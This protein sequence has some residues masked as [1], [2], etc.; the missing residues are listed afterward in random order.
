M[1][2]LADFKI[3]YKNIGKTD[4]EAMK[5]KYLKLHNLSKGAIIRHIKTF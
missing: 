3:P 1:N 4:Y 5:N 2:D